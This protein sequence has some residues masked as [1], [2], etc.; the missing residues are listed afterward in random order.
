MRGHG[1]DLLDHVVGVGG[2]AA[3]D[4]PAERT[5]DQRR[6][7]GAE[8]LKRGQTLNAALRGRRVTCCLTEDRERETVKVIHGCVDVSQG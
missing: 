6:E 7:V 2:G 8:V 1:Q 4:E 3:G 5:A